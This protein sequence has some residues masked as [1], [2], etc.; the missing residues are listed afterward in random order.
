[1]PASVVLAGRL[2]RY[3]GAANFAHVKFGLAGQ[4]MGQELVSFGGLLKGECGG[5][6]GPQR[7]DEACFA[8]VEIVQDPAA[9]QAR[10]V[11]RVGRFIE[12]GS[13]ELRP[14]PGLCA[15]A[16]DSDQHGYGLGKCESRGGFRSAHVP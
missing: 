10:D 7:Y 16:D 8:I 6:G 3:P 15:S 2:R 12:E 5:F 13:L 1:M 9:P 4:R 14:F 11:L